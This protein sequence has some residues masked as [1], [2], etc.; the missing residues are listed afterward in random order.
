MMRKAVTELQHKTSSL[1]LIT[2]G[3]NAGIW[4]WDIQSGEE[5]WSNRFFEILGY[6][7]N[8]IPA[9][10]NTFLNYLLH[11]ADKELI[12]KAIELHFTSQVSFKHDIRMLHKNGNYLWIETSGMAAFDEEGKAIRM[13][14]AIVDIHERKLIQ[15]R[16]EYSE[17][18]LLEAGKM[19]RIGSWELDLVS[20]EIYWSDII[21][22][23]HGLPKE[24]IVTASLAKSLILDN[25]I[26]FVT[27]HSTIAIQEKKSYDIEFQCINGEGKIYWLRTIGWPVLDSS[28]NTLKLRGVMQD[29]DQAKKREIELANLPIITEQ[30]NRLINFAH[31]VSHNLRSHSG[32]ITLLLET[33]HKQES[34]SERLDIIKLLERTA[35]NL[36]E[37]LE[38]LNEVVSI[39]SKSNLQREQCDFQSYYDKTYE[40]V[41]S[42][43]FSLNVKLNIDFKAASAVE[44]IPAYMDSLF[45]NMLTNAIKY[46]HPD[47]Q[48]EITIHSEQQGNQTILSFRDNGMGIDMNRHADKVFGMY[49]TFHRNKDARGIGLFITK[50]QIESCGGKIECSSQ[51]GEGTCFRVTWS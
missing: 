1:L 3:I 9:T 29:I 13:A 49:K 35:T 51:L 22:E 43:I 31:I 46:R 14:G 15:N 23:I 39:Q 30:N 10:Y 5:W 6:E 18:M 47:R 7:V 21:K 42:D 2:E 33:Y 38:H 16:V 37:T 25:Y 27:Q 28:G 20:Q 44:Y 36:S 12:E 11:P 45:L 40:L 50:N 24:T 48:L 32:N 4:D 41:E 26:E 17:A 34:E 8:E 19:A